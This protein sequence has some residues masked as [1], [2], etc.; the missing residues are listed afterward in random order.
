[1]MKRT[2]LST[3]VASALLF[4][5]TSTASADELTGTTNITVNVS[6]YCY[7]MPAADVTINAQVG[8]S[9]FQQDYNNISV[10]CNNSL[11]YILSVDN[12]PGGVFELD[13]PN[14]SKWASSAT[15]I[16]GA[17][18]EVPFGQNEDAFHGVGNGDN[19]V[20]YM[21]LHF[22]NNMVNFMPDVGQWTHTM[23]YTLSF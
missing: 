2:I 12:G 4:G 6:A 3:L 17:N 5:L 16:D 13:G 14:G 10:L 19:Q 18:P 21:T 20:Y 7:L 9:Q 11:P 1:M 23:N 22:G 15:I 8:A